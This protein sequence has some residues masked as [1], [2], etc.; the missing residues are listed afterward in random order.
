METPSPATAPLLAATNIA[1]RDPLSGRQL[2]QPFSLQI[3]A[4]D[5]IVLTGATGSGKSLMLRS[6][7]LI[8]P[9]D[10]GEILL[11]GKPVRG[12]DIPAYRAQVSYVRQRPSLLEDTVEANLRLPYSIAAHA[13]R[14]FERDQVVRLLEAL[15]EGPGFL[16]RLARDLSGGETQLVALIRVL[17]LD[18]L[19]LLLDEPTAALDHDTTLAVEAVLQNWLTAD[20]SRALIMVTH[21]ATQAAR[22]G[23]RRLHIEAGRLSTAEAAGTA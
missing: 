1:R 7:A 9:I 17:Q 23:R 6:L 19:I 11:C 14:R 5:S 13:G 3:F 22:I 12:D 20:A 2:L 21:S 18:P 15:H 16:A 10:D 4:G 8:D